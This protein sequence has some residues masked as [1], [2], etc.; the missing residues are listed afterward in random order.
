MKKKSEYHSLTFYS[1][2]R[3]SCPIAAALLQTKQTFAPVARPVPGRYHLST[4]GWCSASSAEV[5]PNTPELWAAWKLFT[6][7]T[8]LPTC[9]LGHALRICPPH[10]H[11]PAKSASNPYGSLSETPYIQRWQVF[12]CTKPLLRVRAQRAR[13]TRGPS[14]DAQAQSFPSAPSALQDPVSQKLQLGQGQNGA[15]F[16]SPIIQSCLTLVSCV[17]SGEQPL[18]T[19]FVTVNISLHVLSTNVLVKHTIAR[20]FFFCSREANYVALSCFCHD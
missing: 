16:K 19:I 1:H 3:R 17:L 6:T 15:R 13:V 8:K 5:F 12:I 14:R 20:N 9:G 2:F 10:C 7:E 18:G 4:F 11:P